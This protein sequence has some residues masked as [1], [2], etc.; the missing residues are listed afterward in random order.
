MTKYKPH[1]ACFECRKTF[2]RRLEKDIYGGFNK[3]I[4]QFSSK[5]P[6]CGNLMANMGLDFESPQKKDIKKWQHIATLYEVGI[7]FHSCGCSGPGYIPSNSN[8]LI[9]YFLK[10]KADYI[11]HLN[12]WARRKFDPENQSEIAKDSHNNHLYLN[13]LPEK[14]KSGSKNKPQFNAKEAQKYWGKRIVEI[15][16]KI[17]KITQGNTNKEL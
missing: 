9:N 1:Y 17:N 7:T 10:V 3:L 2:K 16:S 6:E 11:E 12:F 4:E 13:Q 14:M 8:E 15:Q 5:C